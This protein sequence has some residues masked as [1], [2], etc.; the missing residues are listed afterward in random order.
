[1]HHLPSKP[2]ADKL[3]GQYWEAAHYIARIL[4]R[5]S[6]ERQYSRF[7]DQLSSGIEPPTSFQAL[8]LAT[9]LTAAISM[10]DEDVMRSFSISKPELINNFRQGTEAALS[11]AHF[12]RTT[13]L[14]TLQ[15]FVV[16]LVR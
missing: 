13:K 1:M 3:L 16:Y 7:W 10:S 12:L 11:K 15:A 6:F 14:E 5:P 4:H 9:I 2:V 8:L